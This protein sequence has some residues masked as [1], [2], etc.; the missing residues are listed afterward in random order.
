MRAARAF[1]NI[2]GDNMADVR[3]AVESKQ[4]GSKFWRNRENF[5]G[6]AQ[7][8]LE[9]LKKDLLGDWSALLLLGGGPCVSP[10]VYLESHDNLPDDLASRK[11]IQSLRAVVELDAANER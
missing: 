7:K 10:G 1:E 2:I 9:R 6:R 5:E 8:A 4:D 3:Q 11:R